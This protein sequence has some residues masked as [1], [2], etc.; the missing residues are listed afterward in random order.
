MSSGVVNELIIVAPLLVSTGC[1]QR[2]RK[3]VA[4]CP[5]LDIGARQG[6]NWRQYGI[7]THVSS[8]RRCLS[9]LD[10]PLHKRCRG[11]NRNRIAKLMRLCADPRLPAINRTDSILDYFVKLV[12]TNLYVYL[13]Q[14]WLLY[15]TKNWTCWRFALW[16]FQNTCHPSRFQ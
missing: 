3:T 10:E 11:D 12:K 8:A 16:R 9:L 14:K 15:F 13:S 7:R 5:S 6:L 4:E 2:A 1:N